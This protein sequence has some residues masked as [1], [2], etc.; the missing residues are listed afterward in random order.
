MD[1]D[2]VAVVSDKQDLG[3]ECAKPDTSNSVSKMEY[4]VALNWDA[5]Y[6]ACKELA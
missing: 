5:H 1:K 2:E 3:S 4:E 6:V